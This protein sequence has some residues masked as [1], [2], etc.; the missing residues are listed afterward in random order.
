MLHHMSYWQALHIK[1]TISQMHIGH[2]NETLWQLKL[3]Q[4]KIMTMSLQNCRFISES[5]RKQGQNLKQQL[6]NT[7]LESLL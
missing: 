5:D 1:K 7:F 6:T 2:I 3:D 4:L